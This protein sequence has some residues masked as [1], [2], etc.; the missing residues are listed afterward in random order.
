[1]LV[2]KDVPIITLINIHFIYFNFF[3]K[4]ARILAEAN[5]FTAV[6]IFLDDL[7]ERLLGF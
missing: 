7:L 6:P 2:K 5:L 1:M 3:P 4:R